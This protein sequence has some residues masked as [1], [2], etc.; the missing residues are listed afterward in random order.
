[1]EEVL[2]ARYAAGKSSRE[3]LDM[4]TRPEHYAASWQAFARIGEAFLSRTRPELIQMLRS[5]RAN[6][7]QSAGAENRA[8]LR[9]PGGAHASSVWTEHWR[10]RDDPRE[11]RPVKS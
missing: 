8:A 6:R 9:R 1:M 10:S 4:V 5:R 7:D 3:D 11:A 2:R